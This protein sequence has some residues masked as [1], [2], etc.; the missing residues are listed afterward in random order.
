[1][2][3]LYDCYDAGQAKG[4]KADD[5]VLVSRPDNQVDDDRNSKG[6]LNSIP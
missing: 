2:V 3:T 5:K 6:I 1:M 4:M